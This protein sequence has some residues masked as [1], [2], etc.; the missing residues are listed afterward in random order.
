MYAGIYA[1]R[2]REYNARVVEYRASL[3]GQTC[4][5]DLLSGF[6]I[7]ERLDK[8]PITSL[9]LYKRTG[10]VCR[11]PMSRRVVPCGRMHAV[12]D[13]DV[14]WSDDYILNE[15]S[16]VFFRRASKSNGNAKSKLKNCL[17]RCLPA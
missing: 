15:T 2:I 1:Q 5:S 9:K 8:R 10:I 3:T 7:I 12:Y 14:N 13:I 17:C 4:S 11:F 6:V 16:S